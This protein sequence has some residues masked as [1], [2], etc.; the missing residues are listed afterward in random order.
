MKLLKA[1]IW[2]LLLGIASCARISEPEEM[3]KPSSEGG[4]IEGSKVR[5]A[6]SLVGVEPATKALGEGGE[7]QTLHLAVFGGS[8]YLK[9]YVEAT[10]V[11]SGTY[12]Y[13]TT[14]A[15]DNPVERTVPRYDFTVDLA[16]SDSPRTV[17]FLGNGPATLP[18]GYDTAVMPSQL[19]AGGEMA[20]WQIISLPNGIRAK[21]NDDGDFID[22]DGHIIPD[23]GTG[24]IADDITE[25]AFQGIPLIR[26]WAKIMLSSA[27][28]SN[29]TPVSFAAVNTPSRGTIAPYSAATGFISNYD[30]ISFTYLEDEIA[31]KANLPAG[32]VFDTD[33]P[34]A[35]AFVPPLGEGIASADGGATYLYERPAPNSS[36]PPSSVII[37]GLYDNPSDQAHKGYYFYKVDLMETKRVGTEFVSRYYPIYRNFKY[38]IIVK[39]I[40][41]QGHATPQAAAASAGSADVSADISTQQ[42]ADISDGIG[43]LHVL[44]WMS[45]TFTREHGAGNPVDVLSVWFGNTDGEPYLDEGRV[46]VQLLPPEDGG[47]DILY[48]LTLYPAAQ[49][50][51]EKGWRKIRFYNVAPSKSVRTQTIRITGVHDDGRLYRDIP[52]TIQPIQPISV[53]CG[54]SR[55]PAVKDTPQTVIIDIPDGLVQSMFPLDFTIEADRKTLTPDNTVP[56][57]S[58][59]V[60]NGPSISENLYYAEKQTFQFVRTITWDEYLAL[61]RFEDENER[62]WRSFTC[63]F[64]TTREESATDVWVYNEFFEKGHDNFV[65]FFYKKF[66]N[67]GFTVPIPSAEDVTLPMSF[68][69][70]EDIDGIYP[71]DYPYVLIK[72]QGVRLDLGGNITAGPDPGTYYVKPSGHTVTLD[73]ISTTSNPDEIEVELSANDYDKATVRAYHFPFA[74]LIDGHPLSNS[75]GYWADN[76]WSNVAWGHVNSDNNKNII[77]GYKDHP[78]KLN[79][80]VTLTIQNGF[81]NGIN[82]KPLVFPYTPTGPRNSNG[83]INYHEIE[84]RTVSGRQDVVFSL[85]SPGYVTIDFR[86]GRFQGNIRTMKLTKSNVFKASNTYGFTVDNPTFNYSED[87]GSVN[88]TFSEVSSIGNDKVIFTAGKTYTMTIT[89]RN[90]AQTLF[91]VDMFFSNRNGYVFSPESIV[92]SVGEV[93]RYYGSNNQF[94]WHIPRGNLSASL[95]FTTQANLDTELTIMYVKSFN[96]SLI[97]NGVTV[98]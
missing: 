47:N 82:N 40:L 72:T 35:S 87:N 98:P 53:R 70:I 19:S 7:L 52:I 22:I 20:Y 36:I 48:N 37:Y 86:Y 32:T 71:A 50:G 76:S 54:E 5:V 43:R 21:R 94:V 29:F 24:Y 11:A 42:L 62:M 4:V 12:T 46:G 41:S 64:K 28:D 96:G 17:H 13:E 55:I 6:L 78:D 56:N 67:L 57:N 77:F 63:H 89:S 14:D 61:Q 16:M 80:P 3:A 84:A 92:P 26:N 30:Q 10:A 85:S 79:T 34:D 91:Y 65:H 66:N 27:E 23:G 38:Q 58:L 49:E 75:S 2:I 31:Y 33:I 74:G 59:P 45:H 68:D 97:D 18:F 1:L 39:K 81:K 88:V 90:N 51:E 83:D 8:G 15:H 73:F 95:E 44:P 9:E 25:L 69:M 93:E 60:I